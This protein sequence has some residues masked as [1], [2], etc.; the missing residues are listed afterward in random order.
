MVRPP[1]SGLLS[2]LLLSLACSGCMTHVDAGNV[3]VRVNSC[4]GGGV[5]PEPVPVGWH[6]VGPCTSIIEYPAFVQTA[7]WTHSTSE[8]NPT[9]E[10]ITFTN[11]DQMSVAA[12]I[13]IAYQLSPEKV[14]AFYSKF[15]ADRLD[16]FTHGFLRNLAREK[17]DTAAGKYRIEQIMGN[18]SSFLVE[19]RTA[20]QRDLDP[21]GVTI[22]QFGFVGA[23]RPPQ[24]VIDSINM[25]IM[26]TQ[27]AVQIENELRQAE[28]SARKVVAQAEGEAK[29]LRT[30]ADAEA[31]A[32][33]K[34]SSSLSPTLVDYRRVQRWDGRM[35]QV[36]GGAVPLLNLSGSSV[37]PK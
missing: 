6:G 37:Q 23:P 36:S 4:S 21:Y 9:N 15:R 24:T 13:S 35:P 30:R 33:L 27:K 28:A 25:K 16:S 2:A 12:D 8:G 5:Q 18:N 20:L 1:F 29:A 26:A 3:G 32:N 22:S 31:Y 19:V 14:P 7:V 34:V 10:E 11:V 17:F